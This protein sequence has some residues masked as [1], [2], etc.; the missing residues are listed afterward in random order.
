MTQQPTYFYRCPTCGATKE[1]QCKGDPPSSLICGVRGC[2]DDQV[3]D[4]RSEHRLLTVREPW[5]S[6]IIFGD[7]NIEN[8]SQ[9]F[10]KKYRGPLWIHASKEWSERGA[11]DPRIRETFAQ[12]PFSYAVRH[13]V[14]YRGRPPHP[15]HGGYVIG[16][17]EVEDIHPAAGCCEP[18][19]E[20]SYPAAN[21]EGR[22]AG[23]VT[24]IVLAERRA[25]A[26]PIPAKGALGLW[27]P[28]EDLALELDAAAL[29]Q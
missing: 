22:P 2:E 3:R 20:E 13:R 18:W 23:V 24:H 29:D 6:A 17:A 1:L 10:P 4:G 11:F 5:A 15:F 9:G 26:Q 12:G 27:R 7:K 16:R 21:A 14:A 19:G 25:L 8:R 28:D